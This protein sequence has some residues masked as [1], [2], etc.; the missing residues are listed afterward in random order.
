MQLL[1]PSPVTRSIPIYLA[2]SP[3]KIV[4]PYPFRIPRDLNRHCLPVYMP[5]N[6]R[7]QCQLGEVGELGECHCDSDASMDE[8]P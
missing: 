3:E 5:I 7:S 4:V 1:R 2:F 6:S 8:G